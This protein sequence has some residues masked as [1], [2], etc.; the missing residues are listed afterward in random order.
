M[1]ASDKPNRLQKFVSYM[2]LSQYVVM[3]SN[4]Q[5]FYDTKRG[6]R[7]HVFFRFVIVGR[8]AYII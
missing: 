1:D 8:I 2:V 5:L 3:I 7:K 6:W 4:V